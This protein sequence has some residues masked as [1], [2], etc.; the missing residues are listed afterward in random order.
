MKS[1]RLTYK[2]EDGTWG[3]KGYDIKK[4]PKELY[5][6]LCKLKDYEETGLMPSQIFEIDEMYT[7]KCRE[8]AAVKEELEALKKQYNTGG[9][10]Q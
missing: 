1:N 2:N 9:G 3:I 7:D 6:A 4:V 5:G 8:L 10:K